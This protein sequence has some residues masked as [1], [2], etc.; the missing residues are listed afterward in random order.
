MPLGRTLA[1]V[2]RRSG[3]G[4]WMAFI[5]G[6]WTVAACSR[7]AAKT[8]STAATAT[9]SSSAPVAVDHPVIGMQVFMKPD[10]QAGEVASMSTRLSSTAEIATCRYL[11][12][13]QS[14][15]YAV[16]LFTSQGDPEAIS[17]LK[18]AA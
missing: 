8:S 11:D 17:A 18:P 2:R 16:K 6:G 1:L 9:T 4:L 12:H 3:A 14:Y 7:S 15:E 5:R 13:L 10:A